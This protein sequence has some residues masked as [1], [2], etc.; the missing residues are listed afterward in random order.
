MSYNPNI[1]QANDPRPQSQYQIKANY[2]A[3]NTVFANNHEPLT[4]NNQ[5]MHDVLTM[6]PQGSD[7][8]TNSAQIALY[9]KLDTSV[10]PIPVLFFM[11]AN[12]ATP[13]Q[14]TSPN[15]STA[16]NQAQ[17]FSFVAGPFVVY[18]GI[19][20]NPANGD[21]VTLSPSTTLKY[22]GLTS[23]NVTA[24]SNL[25]TSAATSISGSS[26]TINFQN[27]TKIDIYYLAIGQ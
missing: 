11:A 1:P 23:A 13:I 2:Q 10:P 22:V 5:G 25:V 14:L 8:T 21:T 12:S 18:G 3:I 7:P 4:S 24:N 26:F 6:R 16:A 17:Q 15:I 19:I 20:K 9:N 27:A